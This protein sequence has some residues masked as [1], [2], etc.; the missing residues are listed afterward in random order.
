MKLVA[1]ES[2]DRQIRDFGELGFRQRRL[3]TGV[4]LLRMFSRTPEARAHI[5]TDL[6]ARHGQQLR[7]AF[8]VL[9]GN[10]L[11]IRKDYWR[12]QQPR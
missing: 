5:V 9:S 8:A 4:L 10:A 6:V 3:H 7:G 11:R 2:V 1:E 12:D